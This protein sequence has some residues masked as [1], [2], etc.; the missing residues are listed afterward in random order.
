MKTFKNI[1]IGFGKGGKTLAMDLGSR[2]EDTLII[3]KDSKMYGGTCIN[4]GCLPTKN[5]LNHAE[6]RKDEEVK[7]YYQKSIQAKKKLIAQFNHGNYKK[8]SETDHVQ[9]LNE[10]A[11]FIDHHTIRVGEQE[12]VGERI[13]INTGSRPALPS[14]EGLKTGGKIYTSET[15]MDEEELPEQLA[16]LGGGPIGLEFANIYQQFGSQVTVILRSKREDFL[17]DEDF[18]V[19]QM[20]LED[21]EKS[22]I[23]FLFET[24]IK[25]VNLPQISFKDG[26][27]LKADALLVAAGRHLNTTGLGLENTD[28][29]FHDKDGI[30]VNDHLQTTVP[31]IYALGDVRGGLQKTYISLDDYRIVR[32]HLFEEGEYSLSDRQFIPSTIFLSPP[33]SRVGH[34]EKSAQEAGLTYDLKILKVEDIPKAK[35][36]G[37]SKGI[38]KTLTDPKTN[39]ILGAVLYGAESHELINSIA[40]A[41]AGGVKASLLKNHIFTHPTLSESFNDI[42]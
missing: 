12:F 3:E 14:I 29:S 24:E 17:G 36:L 34:N 33:L 16:I 23:N 11:S 19:A 7:S 35:V 40:V 1:V 25:R 18:D 41:M 9:V 21:L 2:G 32:S 5:L 27:T 26:E 30:Q 20:V 38:F 10:E 8:V 37:Q 4:V 39:Q 22:G 28:I 6:N 42:F 13:F 31:H 15:L